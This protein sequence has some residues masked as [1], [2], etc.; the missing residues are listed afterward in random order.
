MLA[1]SFPL[2]FN[3]TRHVFATLNVS[4]IL[5]VMLLICV[6]VMVL[7]AGNRPKSR[8]IT[9]SGVQDLVSGDAVKGVRIQSREKLKNIPIDAVTFYSDVS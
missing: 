3:P 1:L 5:F 6:L 4:N 7:S 9:T 2:L 8:P